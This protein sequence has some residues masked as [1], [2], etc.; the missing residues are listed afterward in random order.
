MVRDPIEFDVV[1]LP[2]I[3]RRAIIADVVISEAHGHVASERV[4]QAGVALI[5]KGPR[6]LST[7]ESTGANS[8]IVSMEHAKNS[9]HPTADNREQA[10]AV[11]K[12]QHQIPKDRE[13]I[14]FTV[15]GSSATDGTDAVVVKPAFGFN[16]HVAR[17]ICSNS[18]RA[19][20]T[21]IELHLVVR[22]RLV[23]K[24][25]QFRILHDS[26]ASLVPAAEMR[27]GSGGDVNGTRNT[28]QRQ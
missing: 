1:P 24:G 20:K 8:K 7:G 4:H 14:Q 22:S 23:Q 6:L 3:P 16:G 17:E 21:R 9:A 25:F 19:A 26:G 10:S 15:V 18:Y 11:R 2:A 27:S 28:E 12:L 5:G 13:L